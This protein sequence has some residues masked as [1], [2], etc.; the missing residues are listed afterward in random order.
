V[1]TSP[2]PA[3][4]KISLY[5]ICL[6]TW[7]CPFPLLYRIQTKYTKP[8]SIQHWPIWTRILV[9][10]S[11][12][13]KAQSNTGVDE[14][15]SS[16]GRFT[17]Y[18]TTRQKLSCIHIYRQLTGKIFSSLDPNDTVFVVGCRWRTDVNSSM[19]KPQKNILSC[20][21][22][23]YNVNRPSYALWGV[24]C[25]TVFW[26]SNFTK[27]D[28]MLVPQSAP[29]AQASSERK[30]NPAPTAVTDHTIGHPLR[31]LASSWEWA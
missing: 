27:R 9:S 21:V 12:I 11:L 19:W 2:N 13:L 5:A 4:D 10:L 30:L 8:S 24:Q 22:V 20:R 7:R 1:T 23:P 25:G 16:D 26:Y 31:S 3:Q 14:H 28:C 17:F 6:F 18:G 29:P 15:S